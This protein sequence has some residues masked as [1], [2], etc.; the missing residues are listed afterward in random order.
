MPAGH[1]DRVGAAHQR[2]CQWQ[3]P[4]PARLHAVYCADRPFL[5]ILEAEGFRVINPET[6]LPAQDPEESESN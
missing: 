2:A 5:V 4:R 6:A 3:Q 1:D